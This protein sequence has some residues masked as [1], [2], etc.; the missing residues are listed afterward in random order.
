M[1][2][3]WMY[4]RMYILS[5]RIAFGMRGSSPA[6]WCGTVQSD[7]SYWEFEFTISPPFSLRLSRV[8]VEGAIQ[9]EKCREFAGSWG[10][11]VGA[12]QPETTISDPDRRNGAGLS[13]E[14]NL[15]VGSIQP[16]YHDLVSNLLR[17]SVCVA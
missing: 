3:S 5:W 11:W 6:G 15:A 12:I 2:V 9:S 13:L 8:S 14:V 7:P 1:G 17:D 4:M 10:L 16:I